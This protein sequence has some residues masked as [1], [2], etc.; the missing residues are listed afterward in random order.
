MESETLHK[1]EKAIKRALVSK[2]V[3][4]YYDIKKRLCYN[5]ML[6]EQACEHV[7]RKKVDLKP[8]FQ[9]SYLPQN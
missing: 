6:H 4:A 2:P 9:D 3:Q 1:H 7:L 5:A 8:L